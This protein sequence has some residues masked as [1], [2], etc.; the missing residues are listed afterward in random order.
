MSTL[1]P[2]TTLFRSPERL[3]EA[4]Q[5][6]ACARLDE[7]PADLHVRGL[8]ERVDG[9]RAE[10]R[11]GLLLEHLAHALLE[12]GAQPV[13]RVELARGARQVVVE[14]RQQL[15]LELLHLNRRLRGRAVGLLEVDLLRLARRGAG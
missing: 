5:E 8:D 2:Y 12:I 7:R 4:V 6:L 10:L 13:E 9:G 3:A 11:V 1:F 14:I 15:L